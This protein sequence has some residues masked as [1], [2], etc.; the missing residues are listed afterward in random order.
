MTEPFLQS[1]NADKAGFSA[2]ELLITLIIAMMFIISGYQLYTFTFSR[3]IS[4]GQDARA[5][6]IAYNLL[7][8]Y[9]RS[10]IPDEADTEECTPHFVGDRDANDNYIGVNLNDIDP[11]QQLGTRDVT[12]TLASIQVDCPYKEPYT[13]VGLPGLENLKRITTAITYKT[14]SVTKT[15]SYASYDT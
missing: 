8:A 15:V 12:V 14:G 5:S 11:G 10:E 4:A 2:V 7:Q 1:K 3:S 13:A 9:R 6:D